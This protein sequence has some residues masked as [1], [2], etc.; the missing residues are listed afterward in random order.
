M[1]GS[2][3]QET[4]SNIIVRMPNWLGDIVMASPVLSDLR[5]HYPNARITAMC[6]A[7]LAQ[8]LEKDPNIDELFAF[9]RPSGWIHH[10]YH[11]EVIGALRKGQ[12][13]LGILLT[14]SLS[15]AWNFWR[16]GVQNRLGYVGHWRRYL[17]DKAVEWPVNRETQHLVKTYKQLLGPLGIPL[18]ESRPRL[19][20]ADDE[21]A[22]A[23]QLLRSH[24]VTEQHIVIG[25]NPA[26]AFGTAKCWLPSRF[27][28]VTQQL[29]QNPLVRVVYIGDH[30]GK[31]LISKICVGL[32]DR[33]VNL[34]GKTNLRQL[35]AVIQSCSI[36]L[37]NDS[38]P[39]HIAAAVG[40]PLV[41]LFGSTN[42]V[43][44][45]P[46]KHG[47][48][49]H[50]HVECSPCYK[51]ECPIDFRCMTRIETQEVYDELQRLIQQVKLG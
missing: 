40:T 22:A 31:D 11:G 8:V 7:P 42:E 36:F 45:G 19:Y 21:L 32:P 13:D 20:V 48:V 43:T 46:Y 39:M 37:S 4:P 35:M 51:R 44:T 23:R 26:A 3:P 12:Y 5:E 30:K 9:R 34:A 15:S 17:L 2:W 24:G 47:T 38:G 25:V 18:S 27:R 33:V 10:V 41:A 14:N 1:S 6:Q 49:I 50:K 28:H 16:G 29:L